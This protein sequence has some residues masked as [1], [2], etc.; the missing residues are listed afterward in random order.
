MNLTNARWPEGARSQVNAVF[1]EPKP[2]GS[3]P[4]RE[5]GSTNAGVGQG[6]CRAASRCRHFH[7]PRCDR[8]RSALQQHGRGRNKRPYRSGSY[9]RVMPLA[10]FDGASIVVSG[11]R[12]SRN[13]RGE[14]SVPKGR[15]WWSGAGVVGRWLEM[16]RNRERGVVEQ[17]VEADEAG[18][19]DGA[20]PLNPVFDGLLKCER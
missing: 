18:A 14:R 10:R 6:S 16:A 17:R 5:R 13:G 20:S 7:W 12:L 9:E 8:A 19:S 4:S 15:I 3:S 2:E 11:S 1:S